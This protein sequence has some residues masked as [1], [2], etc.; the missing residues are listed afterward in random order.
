MRALVRGQREPVRIAVT[1]FREK[2]DEILVQ[3]VGR[4][5]GPAGVRDGGDGRRLDGGRD[6]AG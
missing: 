3:G 1:M 6:D 5:P 2:L 4:I